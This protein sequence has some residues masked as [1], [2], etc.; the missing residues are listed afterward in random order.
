LAVEREL[1]KEEENMRLALKISMET[2]GN[3]NKFLS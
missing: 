2:A 3:F 1:K